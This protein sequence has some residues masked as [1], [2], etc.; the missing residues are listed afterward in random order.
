MTTTGDGHKVNVE[1]LTKYA[2]DLGYYKTEADK[3]GALVDKADVTN[4]SWGLIGLAVKDTYTGKLAELRELLGLM[5][6]GVDAFSDKLNKA[7]SIYKGFDDDAKMVFGK[8]EATIDGP[9]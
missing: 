5:K 9:R 1:A 2:T 6:T 7:A 3:F 4:E 8:Y